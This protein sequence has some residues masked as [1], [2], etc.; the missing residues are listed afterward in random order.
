MKYAP[1]VHEMFDTASDDLGIERATQPL[2]HEIVLP[3]GK[4][5]GKCSLVDDEMNESISGELDVVDAAGRPYLGKHAAPTMSFA[6]RTEQ[7]IKKAV[8]L[9]YPRVEFIVGSAP[10]RKSR[11]SEIVDETKKT[12]ANKG[13][14]TAW[15]GWSALEK[16]MDQAIVSILMEA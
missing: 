13:Y 15:S 7:T 1:M 3:Q 10:A 8:E 9:V 5:T 6:Q 12:L 11:I 14:A 16:S 4:P 2:V